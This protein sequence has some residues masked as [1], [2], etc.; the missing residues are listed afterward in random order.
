MKHLALL[1]AVFLL[2]ACEGPLTFLAGE[3]WQP[4]GNAF[5]TINWQGDSADAT[6]LTFVTARNN[7]EWMNLWKRVGAT[8]PGELPQGKMAVA[9]LA[10]QRP[11]PGWKAEIISAVKESQLGR[12]ERFLVRYVV[13]EPKPGVV[14]PQQL[15]SPWAIRLADEVEIVP[16]FAEVKPNRPAKAGTKPQK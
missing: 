4:Q 7:A 1:F 12:G 11:N 16:T 9:V 8:A 3:G 5:K 2:A 13:R 6:V 10:G 14:Y 15:V